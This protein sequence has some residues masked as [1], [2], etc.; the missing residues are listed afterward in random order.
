LHLRIITYLILLISFSQCKKDSAAPTLA[1]PTPEMCCVKESCLDTF[2]NCNYSHTLEHML[3]GGIIGPQ[4][5]PLGDTLMFEACFN[6]NNSNQICLTLDP[7]AQ[8]PSIS[9]N[10][11]VV[12]ACNST[13][14]TIYSDLY[15]NLSWT[16]NNWIL[17]TGL[18]HQI[19][20]IRPN[21]DSLTALFND[22][23]YNRA[24]K[25]N[26]SSSL[27]WNLRNPGVSFPGINIIDLEGNLIKTLATNNHRPINWLNDSTIV[28]LYN[29]QLNSLTIGSETVNLLSSYTFNGVPEFT[30]NSEEKKMIAF[31]RLGFGT[32]DQIIELALDGSNQFNML[33]EYW[34]SH[35]FYPTDVSNTHMIGTLKRY[36]WYNQSNYQLYEKL[37]VAISDL[38]GNNIRLIEF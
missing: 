5:Y 11:V 35:E 4:Y 19:F 24:G 17:F 26:P 37:G 8:N 33:N 6:P 15:Y 10:L 29:N 25:S 21:G 28:T 36:S 14:E 32:R 31:L 34:D 13:T 22:A 9:D 30:Y 7:Y 1:E 2:T 18:N 27:L 38:E 3:G 12:D 16:S 20:K 23:G